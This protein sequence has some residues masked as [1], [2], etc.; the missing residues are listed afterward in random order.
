M[1]GLFNDVV[2]QLDVDYQDMGGMGVSMEDLPS[3]EDNTALQ[4][5]DEFALLGLADD[6]WASQDVQGMHDASQQVG[7]AD[8]P[9]PGSFQ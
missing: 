9:A 7:R 8:Q 3:E 6:S 2:T 4:T 5:R 1:T